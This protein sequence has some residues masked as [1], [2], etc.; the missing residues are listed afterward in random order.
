MAGSFIYNLLSVADVNAAQNQSATATVTIR[1]L[2]TASIS[3]SAAIPQ[4]GTAPTITFTGANGTAPYTFTYNING[5]NNSTITSNGNMATVAAPTTSVGNFVY[6]LVNVADV[7]C[8]QA[9]TGSATVMVR[10][11]PLATITGNTSVCN[12]SNSPVIT[13]TG[14]AGTAPYTFTYTINGGSNRTITTNGTTAT[15]SVPTNVTG[16]F[17][18]RLISVTDAFATQTQS[19]TATVTVNPLPAIN[20]NSNNVSISKGEAIILT[21]TGGTQ[22]SWAG[23]DIISGQ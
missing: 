3:G 22:Y 23:A 17:V 8:G 16:T 18:Y 13:F 19:G 12:F 21:A 9:Q 6:N 10:P 15:L 4:N 11:L 2:A 1:T 7:N 14:S 5:G 20:I